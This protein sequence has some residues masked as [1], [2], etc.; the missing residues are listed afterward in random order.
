MAATPESQPTAHESAAEL[1][2]GDARN[3]NGAA[4]E[5]APSATGPRDLA[6]PD[7]L[8]VAAADGDSE[9]REEQKHA[10]GM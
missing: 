8:T 6:D 2:T 10:G 7:E 9:P 3:Q 4:H 5:F 1:V